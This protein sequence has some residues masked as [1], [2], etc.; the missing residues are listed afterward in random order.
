MCGKDC[1]FVLASVIEIGSPPHLRE[2]LDF[3]SG[4]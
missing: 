4:V 3:V 1:D 2:G